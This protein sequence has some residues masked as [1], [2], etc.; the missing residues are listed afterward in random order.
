[1]LASI[2]AGVTLPKTDPGGLFTAYRSQPRF[3]SPKDPLVLIQGGKRAFTHDSTVKT[4]NGM[5]VCRTVPVTELS[6]QMPDTNVRFSVRGEDILEEVSTTAV[7]LL[8]AI[9]CCARRRFWTAAA[10]AQLQCMQPARQPVP[11][12]TCIRLNR[13][14]RWSR[15]PGTHLGSRVSTTGRYWPIV[16]SPECCQPALP[17]RRLHDP[18]LPC[19]CSGVVNSCPPQRREGLDAG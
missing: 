16:A 4:E 18:G 5:I 14:F 13:T 1:V 3:Y 19:S 6:W 7:S 9:S 8:S 2:Q 12:S 15:L 10:Q 17:L 11:H